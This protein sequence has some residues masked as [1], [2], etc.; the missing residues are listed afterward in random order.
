M[1]GGEPPLGRQMINHVRQVLAQR[2]KQ[3]VAFHAG[4]FGENSDGILP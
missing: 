2:G 4:L 3:V 1:I